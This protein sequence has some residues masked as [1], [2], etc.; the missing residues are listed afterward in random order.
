MTFCTGGRL[1]SAYRVA[2]KSQIIMLRETKHLC[3]SLKINKRIVLVHTVASVS[4]VFQR[5]FISVGDFG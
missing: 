2:D 1:L 4:S 5:A 3:Y